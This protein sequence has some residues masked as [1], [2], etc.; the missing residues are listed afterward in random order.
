MKFLL[1]SALVGTAYA[2]LAKME[3]T[4]QALANKTGSN[5]AI[6][7]LMGPNF[8]RFNGY[9]CWCY[10]EDSHG[11]GKSQPVNEVDAF[12]KLLHEGYDC[13]I[14]DAEEAGGECSPWEVDYDTGTQALDELVGSC[15]QKNAGDQCKIDACVV[16]GWFVT[17][18]FQL[19]F[20]G[21]QLDMTAK[22]QEDGTGFDVDASCPTTKG[23]FS[24]KSCCGFAPY[25][26]P[27]KTYDGQRACCGS[28]T[29]DVS[30][31]TCCDDGRARM[32]C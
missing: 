10:F 4:F 11:M 15:S 9:G 5:R 6:S 31:L 20:G 18:I 30:V 17:S 22:H 2:S 12:C 32:T 21:F 27:F 26:H 29:F 7:E 23:E 24:E 13:A 14:M 1:N 8:E 25:R 16:E 19:F 28:K 3:E